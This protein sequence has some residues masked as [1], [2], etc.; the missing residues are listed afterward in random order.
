ME[1]EDL[2]LRELRGGHA[3]QLL[4]AA[5]FALHGLKVEVPQLSI[6]GDAQ[7]ARIWSNSTD[8]LLNGWPV[9]IKS[10][11][12]SFTSAADYPFDTAFVDTVS[13]YI[14]KQV[15]PLAYVIVSR[16]TGA[17]L[18]LSVAKTRAWWE[19]LAKHDRV[20]DIDE[21]F[22]AIDKRCLQPLSVLVEALKVRK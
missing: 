5:F 21:R 17:M 7:D 13:G 16:P 2:F 19:V 12:E 11:R 1:D 20:R 15:K 9:E 8:I 18:C 4:P 22:Y 14:A 3:W 10:R 6:R